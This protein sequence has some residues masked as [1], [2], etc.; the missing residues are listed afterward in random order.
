[1]PELD[2]ND[3]PESPYFSTNLK[4]IKSIKHADYDKRM[5]GSKSHISHAQSDKA[6]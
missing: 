5:D 1:M 4:A 2:S 3:G 6:Q